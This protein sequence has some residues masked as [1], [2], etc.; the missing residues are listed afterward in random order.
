MQFLKEKLVFLH[1]FK[2]QICTV[3][4]KTTYI[5]VYVTIKKN[6]GIYIGEN[7]AV[8]VAMAFYIKVF[9]ARYIVIWSY[10]YF[11]NEPYYIA[12]KGLPS[13]S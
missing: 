12:S 2:Y 5:G 7:K 4:H 10:I 8:V 6:A 3:F 1:I 9:Q 13:E 11:V